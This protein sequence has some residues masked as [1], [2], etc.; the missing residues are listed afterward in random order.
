L[1]IFLISPMRASCLAHLVLLDLMILVLFGEARKLWGS[2]LWG[3][4]QPPTTSSLLGL[5][6][7]LTTLFS[8]TLTL[9]SSLSVTDQVSH[10]YKTTGS[11][12]SRVS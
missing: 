4:S 7:V 6:T 3:P 5:N 12:C 8:D 2:S 9:C 10:P 1:Y 11:F